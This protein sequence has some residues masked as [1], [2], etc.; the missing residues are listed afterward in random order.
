[1]GDVLTMVGTSLLFAL[2]MEIAIAKFRDMF[3]RATD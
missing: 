2:G 1:M 3:W